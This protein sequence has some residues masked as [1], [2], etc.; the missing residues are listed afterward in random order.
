MPLSGCTSEDSL[1]G[2][3]KH[4]L[5]E[6]KESNERQGGTFVRTA[7]LEARADKRVKPDVLLF[8]PSMFVVF[9]VVLGK[10]QHACVVT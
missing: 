2:A 10:M 1:K 4:V 5:Q 8:P 9:A 6:I 3:F 7:V